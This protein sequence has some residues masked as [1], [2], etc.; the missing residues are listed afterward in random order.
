MRMWGQAA[1]DPLDRSGGGWGSTAHRQVRLP[2]VV[3]PA[4]APVALG[5]RHRV[6][7]RVARARGQRSEERA[8]PDWAASA[9][10]VVVQAA[11]AA[12]AAAAQRAEVAGRGCSRCHAAAA[13]LVVRNGGVAAAGGAPSSCRPCSHPADTRIMLTTSC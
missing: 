12:A 5:Q 10:A 2:P 3:A 7:T 13:A 4:V 6:E 8:P 11:V 1:V 9:V